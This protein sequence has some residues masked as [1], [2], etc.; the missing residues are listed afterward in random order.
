MP[1]AFQA[2]YFYRVVCWT[3]LQFVLLVLS[4]PFT[5]S[6]TPVFNTGEVSIVGCAGRRSEGIE[7]LKPNLIIPFK[8]SSY[9]IVL[10]PKLCAHRS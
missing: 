5:E 2:A 3:V 6:V 10:I 8:V 9:M 7:T 4:C 1:V